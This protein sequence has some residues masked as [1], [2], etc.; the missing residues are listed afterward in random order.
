MMAVA[1]VVGQVA[2]GFV[3]PE[4]SHGAWP[5]VLPMALAGV[6]LVLIAFAWLPRLPPAHPRKES[7]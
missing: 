4:L 3:D 2:A 6:A 7:P 5:M 1:F